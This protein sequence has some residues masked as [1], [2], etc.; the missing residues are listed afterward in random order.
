M[1]VLSSK[2][3]IKEKIGYGLGDFAS[4]LFYMTF[5][6]FGMYFYTNVFKIDPAAV[7]V[8][9]IVVRFWDAIFD[10]IIGSLADRTSTRWGRFRPYLLWAAVP[11]GVIGFL[12]FFSPQFSDSGR[13]VYA[14]ITYILMMMVY[15]AINIPYSAML[16][17]ITSNTSERTSL[18]SYKFIA[19]F[20]A[21]LLVQGVTLGLVNYFGAVHDASGVVMRTAE[22]NTIIDTVIGFR[23]TIGLY[24][25]LA[26]LLFLLT[27]AA[28]KER[29]KAVVQQKSSI[30]SDLKDLMHNK[31]W[32][33]LFVMGLATISYASIRNGSIMYY[34]KYYVGTGATLPFVGAV[35][36]DTLV[37]SFM[38]IGTLAT[39]L[40]TAFIKPLSTI[41]GKHRLFSILAF[42]TAIF[43][44]SFFFFDK[45]SIGPMFVFQILANLTMGPTSALVWAM[46]ADTADYSE[47]QNG[48]KA[49]GLIFS[50]AI[51]SQKI[52]WA[53][54]GAL[55]G[56]LLSYY[57]F[58][59]K[60]ATQNEGTVFG[61]CMMLSVIPAVASVIAGFL[62][63]F[64]KLT[65]KRMKEIELELTKRRGEAA[66][67]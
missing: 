46:Y 15:S 65:D 66:S 50:A 63:M 57:G 34:F 53:I 47:Y 59:E 54:G 10:V 41:F 3:S 61:I 40:G 33:L 25:V 2:V 37:S 35:S 49:T 4:N 22:G 44:V 14:Y 26:I 36:N 62:T 27:F 43:T 19:A 11:Y 45:D 48:R 29:I 20:S 24:A 9:F 17:V 13:L 23:V 52:G 1:N 32:L 12:T 58:D 21:G 28:T 7:A 42:L 5:I 16:G 55:P 39:I 31:P 51:M 30:V 67:V 8:M 6:Y 56:L 64:Y 60:V 18:S 38:V